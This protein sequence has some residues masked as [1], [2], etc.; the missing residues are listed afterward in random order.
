MN[1]AQQDLISLAARILL[2]GLFIFSG[3]NKILHLEGTQAFMAAAGL[4]ATSILLLLTIILELVAGTMILVGYQARL[5]ALALILFLIPVTLIFHNPLLHT[6]AEA[7][8]Q[9][10]IHLLK[11]LAIMGGLLHVLAFG[12]GGLSIRT[13]R[14]PIG[15]EA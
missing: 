15:Q 11:N 2:A 1:Q 14:P 4:P 3:I 6:D 9:H 12:S 7:I 5:A 13:D 8:R 10:T